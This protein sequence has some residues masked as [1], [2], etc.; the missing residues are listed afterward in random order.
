MSLSKICIRRPAMTGILAIA[1]IVF[2]VICLFK[3]PVSDLPNVQVPVIQVQASY[4]GF[5]PEDMAEN[6]SLPLQTEFLGIPGITSS[7]TMNISGLSIAVLSF[8]LDKPIAEAEADTQKA[9]SA[10]LAHLPQDMPQPPSFQVYNPSDQPIMY[11]AIN[12]QTQTETDL[13]NYAETLLGDNIS[14]LAGVG[15]I[16][17]FGTDQA[18]R[19]KVDPRKL[20]QRNL[21]I[22]E[23][24]EQ[25]R[26]SSTTF[27]GGRVY[28]DDKSYELA[29]QGQIKKAEDYEEVIVGQHGAKPIYLRDIGRVYTGKR[30]E[31]FSITN[32]HRGGKSSSSVV[33]AIHKQ[34]GAN[35]VAV[36]DSIES[37]FPKIEKE[38]PPSIQLETVYSQ[39]GS[40]IKS[41]EDVRDTLLIAFV[42]VVVVVFLFLGRA[43]ATII[44]VLALPF[45]IIGSAIFMLLFGFSVN[46][47]TLLGYVLIIGFLVDDAIVMLENIF[48]HIEKGKKPFQAAIDGSHEVVSTVISMSASLIAVFLPL[49]FLPGVMGKLFL[50]F[51]MIVV[52]T[53]ALSGVIA[54][55]LIPMLCSR[56]VKHVEESKVEKASKAVM[57]KVV[58]FYSPLL[59]YS[60][61][62]RMKVIALGILSLVCSLFIY[63]ALPKNFLPAGDT[64]AILGIG[65]AQP[66]TG[67]GRVAKAQDHANALAKE[68]P[69]VDRVISGA[70][71]SF[72]PA[73]ETK[74]FIHL[75]DKEPRPT[76]SEVID[77]LREKATGIVGFMPLYTQLVPLNLNTSPQSSSA[78]YQYTLST[79]GNPN[80]LYTGAAEILSAMKKDSRFVQVSSNVQITKPKMNITFNRQL[81][82]FYGIT[83]EEM[84]KTIGL[85]FAEG[86]INTYNTP[87]D[88]QKVVFSLDDPFRKYVEALNY[89]H[90]R[91]SVSPEE[92][93]NVMVPLKSLVTTHMEAAPT[94]V[95]QTGKLTSVTLS[96]DVAKGHSLSEAMSALE[97]IAD[98]EVKEKG[99]LASFKGQAQVFDQVLT[100]LA[101]LLALAIF[102]VYVILTILYESFIHPIT[103]LSTLPGVLFG[104]L[105]TLW[106]MHQELSLYSYIAIFVVLGIV[107]KNGIIIVDFANQHIREGLHAID[108]VKKACLERFRPILMTTIAAGM[109]AVPIAVGMGASGSAEMPLGI[110][111]VGGLIISQLVTLFITP[112]VY[113]YLE[114]LQERFAPKKSSKG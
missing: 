103:I 50:E 35:T 81:A 108:A 55:T 7:E 47:L 88:L 12:S 17:Y 37:L 77:L 90:I 44:P 110:G 30:H 23:V 63:Q 32:W 3:L 109:G 95:F 91:S 25:L 101:I 66:G 80:K 6:V 83:A 85:A 52:L 64:G 72:M 45:S 24:A 82:G 27:P 62:H 20:A 42:L 74:F 70:N 40:I 48:R 18:I 26:R 93:K 11:L 65:V 34:P 102:V 86:Q 54:V 76:T 75:S 10:A 49:A 96:F 4:P 36:I 21:N 1:V 112:C 33:L 107:L 39:K 68:L 58:K 105:F 8:D 99:L 2:G 41:V 16:A 92:G 60:L 73:N 19:I 22:T 15:D 57:A 13:Y 53:V 100:R 111:I 78:K 43:S 69:Y 97:K 28:T 106:V 61:H 56:F 59:D 71:L 89:L 38:L 84:A 79:L 114:E 94:A 113:V 98:P 29:S 67:P 104:T 5:T 46:I 51:A 14:I 87:S 31:N 9:I